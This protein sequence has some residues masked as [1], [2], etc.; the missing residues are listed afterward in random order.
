MQLSC[1]LQNIVHY[2]CYL[3]G[4]QWW[5]RI[6]NLPVLFGFVSFKEVVV[7]EGLQS[8]SFPNRE[9]PALDGIIVNEVVPILVDMGCN[10]C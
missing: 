5:Y 9:A 6:A 2:F 7:G 4:K 1:M 3:H 10:G 8:G